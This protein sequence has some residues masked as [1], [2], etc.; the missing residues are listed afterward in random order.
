MGSGAFFVAGR[1]RCVKRLTSLEQPRT[2]ED[3]GRI[4][5]AAVLFRLTLRGMRT[6]RSV[7]EGDT[8]DFLVGHSLDQSRFLCLRACPQLRDGL[9]VRRA[10]GALG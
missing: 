7:F 3:K 8:A 10:R 1:Q 4:A 5:E 2:R 9:G 6:F